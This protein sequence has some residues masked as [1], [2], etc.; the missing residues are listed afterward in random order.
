MLPEITH[1]VNVHSAI[2][3]TENVRKIFIAVIG[4]HVR[5]GLQ[6]KDIVHGG[7]LNV[8]WLFYAFVR[9]VCCSLLAWASSVTGL[10]C[11]LLM[12]CHGL[13]IGR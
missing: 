7:L 5:N 4:N 9:T 2:P 6:G 8:R 10:E 13:F 3:K 11:V 12:P 1:V